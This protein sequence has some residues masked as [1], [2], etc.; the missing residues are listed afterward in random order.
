[1]LGTVSPIFTGML[2]DEFGIKSAFLFSGIICLI[3]TM[4]L[5][6][7]KLPMNVGIAD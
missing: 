7:V 2:I 1:L 3:A 5:L 6:W 4:L